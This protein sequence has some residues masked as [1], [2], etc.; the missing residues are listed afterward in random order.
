MQARLVTRIER[1]VD[2]AASALFAAAAAYA[3]YESFAAHARWP[4]L[5]AETAAVALVAF[6]I[7][8]RA[9]NAIPPERRRL[10]VP[11]FDVREI[12]P[13]E[14]IEPAELMLSERYEPAD[15]RAEEPLVLDDVLAALEP[16]SRVV[17]LFDPA[18]MPTPG[19]LNQRIEHH[20]ERGAPPAPPQDASQAL[21]D[22]LAE[23][24]R[25]LR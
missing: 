1:C 18:A 11:V 6:V 9:L 8:F 16:D 25:S 12:E 13:I 21:H 3:A 14:P 5:G 22:A 24:R 4:V 10:P 17:R 20:S 2:A 23:L 15:A 19:Q 7:C